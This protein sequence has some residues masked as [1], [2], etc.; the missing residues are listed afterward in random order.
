MNNHCQ[1]RLPPYRCLE[2]PKNID[3]LWHFLGLVGFFRKLIPFFADVTACLNTMPWKGAVF[4]WNKHCNNVF[5]L[6]ESDLVKMPR[7]QYLNPNKPWK[8]FTGTSKYS[9]LGILHQEEVSDQP[10]AEPNLVPIAYFSGS[11]SKTQQLWNT[12]QKECYAVYWS[13]QKCSCYLAGTKCTLYCD[14]KLLA[15]F[16]TTGM[17]SPV[18]SHWALELQQFDIQFIQISGKRNIVADA[19][20]W[21]RTLAYTKTM[22]MMT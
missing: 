3:E 22:A 2:P 18:L 14:Y 21:L 5:N 4:K 15:S 12:T 8:L 10:N 16:F 6:L 17:S 1:R 19:I 13:I 20:S 9:Y 7:L 11:F